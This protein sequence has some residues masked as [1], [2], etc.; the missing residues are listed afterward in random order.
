MVSALGMFLVD[1]TGRIVHANASG[2]A[3]L[4]EVLRLARNRRQA[5]SQRS[6]RCKALEETFA[7]CGN[8]D[9]AVGTKGIAVPLRRATAS[10]TSR[11]Y[12]R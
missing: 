4:H 12:F 2:H 11:T 7:A 9:A 10:T 1:A 8:G 3:M 6:D 5:G